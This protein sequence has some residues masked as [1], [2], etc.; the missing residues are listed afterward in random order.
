MD[1]I[2]T[3]SSAF[4]LVFLAE[5]G[6]KSQLVCMTLSARYRALPVLVAAVLAFS[7][8]NLLAVTV[9]ATLS[10]WLPQW[11]VLAV[12][13]LL[14]L[15]FGV[16]SLRAEDEDEEEE[17]V[18]VGKHLVFSVF[19]LIFL[20]E[21]GDKTQLAVAGLGS[22]EAALPVWIGSTAAL[23]TTSVLGVIAGRTV[24]QRLPLVWVHRVSGVIFILFALLA[25]V[26]LYILLSEVS[27]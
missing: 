26:E 15:W 23:I 22:V 27:P 20:A 12:V 11:V 17:T 5:F 9:G 19:S 24:L 6:D 2:S 16:V 1:F 21:L 4:V 7:L 8:L 14:F 13:V 3:L 10:L 18:K 25:A